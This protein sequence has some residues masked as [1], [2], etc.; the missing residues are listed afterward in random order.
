MIEIN[1]RMWK[2]IENRY[3][4]FIEVVELDLLECSSIVL[5]IV[6]CLLYFVSFLFLRIDSNIDML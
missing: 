1:N 2:I 3:M 6:F 5:Y 4:V